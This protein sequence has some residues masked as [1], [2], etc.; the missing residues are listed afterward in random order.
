MRQ[1]SQAAARSEDPP[2]WT[3][4]M[5][6]S[7]RVFLRVLSQTTFTL[8]PNQTPDRSFQSFCLVTLPVN[9]SR[10]LYRV[11]PARCGVAWG[12]AGTS[13]VPPTVDHCF[14]GLIHP[15]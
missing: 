5:E 13:S 1:P 7:S 3:L 10:N 8:F 15:A 14:T 9:L 12:T 11:L 6:D 2:M 4:F